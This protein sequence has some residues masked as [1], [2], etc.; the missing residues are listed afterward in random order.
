MKSNYGR[1]GIELRLR[2][3]NGCFILDGPA[4]GFDKLAAEAKADHVFLDLLATFAAQGRDVSDSP[5]SNYAPAEF[6]GQETMTKDA[7]KKA[8]KRLLL[9]GRIRVDTFGPPS[10]QRKRLVIEPPKEGAG[11]NL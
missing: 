5:G 2:W 11:E 9:A 8:M 10:R 3:L 4:G 6:A 7:L 1:V